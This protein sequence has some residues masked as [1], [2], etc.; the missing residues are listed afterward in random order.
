MMKNLLLAASLLL[1]GFNANAVTVLPGATVDFSFS[2]PFNPL[3]G[4]FHVEGDSLRFKP[5]DFVATTTGG[6]DI[7]NA[8]TPLITVTARP[9]FV[10]TELNLFEQGDYFRIE[11]APNTTFVGVGGQF[12]VNNNPVQINADQ[13]LNNAF[14]FTSLATGTPFVTTPWTLSE[15][16]ALNSAQSATVRLENILVAGVMS[17][18]SAAFIEK[19]L[20]SIGVV[21]VPVPAAFWLFAT[22]LLTLVTT[23]RK[24]VFN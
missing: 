10:L 3:F 16:V 19:K 15:S 5:T 2:V 9:G 23:R 24:A 22:G 18:F 13:G 8:T 12:I 21:T 17:N 1:A 20:I 4:A 14:S 7:T 11:S 6:I